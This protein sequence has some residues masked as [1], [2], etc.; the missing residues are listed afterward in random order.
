M[1]DGC[2]GLRRPDVTLGT[3]SKLK[4]NAIDGRPNKVLMLQFGLGDAL[5]EVG[6][7]VASDV[8][9]I[10]AGLRMF[11][12]S[13]ADFRGYVTRLPSKKKGKRGGGR[14]EDDD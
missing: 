8:V 1:M 14:I 3:R 9:L 11:P 12:L 6:V 2:I 13:D 7:V 5:T 4:I 10:S